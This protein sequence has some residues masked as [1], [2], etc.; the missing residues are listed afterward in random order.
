MKKLNVTSQKG[1]APP[2][3]EHAS[4]LALSPAEAAA[5]LG[6]S[7][8]YFDKHVGPLVPMVR[9]GRRKLVPAKALEQW[10]NT[11]AEAVRRV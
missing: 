1:D 3:G 2:I 11:I 4:R 7:R 6:V 5:A 10:L 8:D 9:L